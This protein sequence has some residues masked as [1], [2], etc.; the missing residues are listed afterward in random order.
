MFISKRFFYLPEMGS[1]DSELHSWL[2]I[3]L[4]NPTSKVDG[5][6][7]PSK[8]VKGD[9]LLAR[10]SHMPNILDWEGMSSKSDLKACYWSALNYHSLS[11]VQTHSLYS[12]L[13]LNSHFWFLWSS[14]GVK[15]KI[16]MFNSLVHL[17]SNI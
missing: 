9:P 11:L 1:G 14:E 10:P 2:H 4:N 3:V 8:T 17:L 5:E 6:N 13:N 7:F 15:N 16:N 12:A